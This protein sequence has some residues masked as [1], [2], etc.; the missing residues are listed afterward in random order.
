MEF[1]R[2]K[3]TRDLGGLTMQDGRKIKPGMLI[4]SSYLAVA[5]AH[6]LAILQNTVSDIVDFRTEKERQERPDPEMA[7]VTYHAQPVLADMTAG[8]TREE[9]ADKNEIETYLL[10]PDGARQHMLENYRLFVTS[11]HARQCYRHFVELL[12]APR[13]KAILWHC[14][15]GKDRAGFAAAIVLSILGADRETILADYMKTNAGLAR[16]IQWIYPMIEKQAGIM[17]ETMRKALDYMFLAR[18]EYLLEAFRTAEEKHGSMDAY[19]KESLG[20]DDA[21]RKGLQDRYLQD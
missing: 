18:E 14:T 4:R 5:P 15:A 13:E 2:L 10:D 20:V 3:N 16:E 12:A 7:G 17:T 21:M 6:D 9:E 1:E 11:D 8:I 19:L